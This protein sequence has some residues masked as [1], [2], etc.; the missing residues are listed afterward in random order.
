[1]TQ[2][3][4]GPKTPGLIILE[5]E[6]TNQTVQAFIDAYPLMISSGWQVESTA[7]V[8]DTSVYLNSEDG[9]SPVEQVNGVLVQQTYSLP[10]SSTSSGPS[11]PTSTGNTD[12]NTGTNTSQSGGSESIRSTISKVAGALGAIF[13]TVMFYA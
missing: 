13:L 1:M 12:G 2:W 3:L 5:H 9:N 7:Q 10:G 6:L 4:T 11:S 8:N